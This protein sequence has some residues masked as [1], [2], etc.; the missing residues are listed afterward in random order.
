MVTL[1]SQI[2]ESFV[3]IT[4]GIIISLLNKYL[5]NGTCCE[6]VEPEEVDTESESDDTTTKKPNRQRF[7]DLC[8]ND[9][10]F[11]VAPDSCNSPLLCSSFIKFDLK[12]KRLC[13]III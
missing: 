13:I 2:T 6:S 8:D 1:P 5:I 12:E 7:E 9:S 11:A 3:P 10:E 4:A